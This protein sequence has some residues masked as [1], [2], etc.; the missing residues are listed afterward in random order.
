MLDRI[1]AAGNRIPSLLVGTLFPPRCAGCGRR[2][3]WVC[4]DCRSRFP[5]LAAPLC[6][7]CGEPSLVDCRCHG[8]SHAIDRMRSAGWYEGWLR[9]AIVTFKYE[10]E[11]ARAKHLAELLADP[12]RSM[13][14]D[15][16]LVPVPLHPRRERSRGYNQA[17]ELSN[18]LARIAGLSVQ[19]ILVRTQPTRQQVGL[20]AIDRVSNVRGAFALAAGA[21][22][23]DERIVLVDDVLTTGATLG[24]CA[25]VL[26][27]AGAPFVG[28]VTLA[29]ER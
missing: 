14:S 16:V 29:R 5:A 11:S 25:E 7:R 3:F 1:A 20:S 21:A 27:S 22:R 10:G 26:K 23:N 4:P 15:A 12:I 18:A 13:P 24:A 17:L 19:T 28:A 6:E 2:G 9:A 8:L